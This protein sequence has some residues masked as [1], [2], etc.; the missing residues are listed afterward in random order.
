MSVQLNLRGTLT[1][2]QR[3][4][5]DSVKYDDVIVTLCEVF[6]L[7]RV[8][9]EWQQSRQVLRV[10]CKS[11]L[12]ERLYL[13]SS[14][15]I[16]PKTLY[17]SVV[18][19]VFS[20]VSLLIFILQLQL[21][22]SKI[23]IIIFLLSLPH[24]FFQGSFL[25]SSFIHSSDNLLTFFSIR[26]IACSHHWFQECFFNREVLCWLCNHCISCFISRLLIHVSSPSHLEWRYLCNRWLG[27]RDLSSFHF[28]TKETR[29]DNLVLSLEHLSLNLVRPSSRLMPQR[30]VSL[31]DVSLECPLFPPDSRETECLLS[32]NEWKRDVK[33][34][35]L[36][37][38]GTHCCLW[39][40]WASK[41]SWDDNDEDEGKAF[42]FRFPSCS[43]VC[44]P[45]EGQTE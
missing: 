34:V 6:A 26:Q 42:S 10:I 8:G 33:N 7:E 21:G 9:E 12:F 31:V 20:P 25:W 14:R 39:W 29:L 16:C 40:W 13:P 38:R 44:L 37:S 28:Y 15:V 3:N 18:C 45:L 2:F 5:S 32:W 17:C 19:F 27:S 11:P 30:T 1:C 36:A 23:S 22:L 35:S 43:F 4:V 41:Q 24:P